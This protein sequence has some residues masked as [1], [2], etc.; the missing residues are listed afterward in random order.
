MEK[1]V[2]VHRY[3]RRVRKFTNALKDQLLEHIAMGHTLASFLWSIRNTPRAMSQAAIHKQLSRDPEFRR[4]YQLAREFGA[5][6]ICDRIGRIIDLVDSSQNRGFKRPSLA[7][8]KNW[9]PKNQSKKRE[10]LIRAIRLL[11]LCLAHSAQKSCSRE[12]CQAE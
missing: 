9:W 6:M 8:I 4:R 12:G 10:S 5:D 7:I 2:S 11:D 1:P 3:A